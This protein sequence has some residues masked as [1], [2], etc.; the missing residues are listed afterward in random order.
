MFKNIIQGGSALLSC[1]LSIYWIPFAQVPLD[2]DAFLL[3]ILNPGDFFLGGISFLI[4]FLTHANLW[5][6][7]IVQRQQKVLL[8]YETILTWLIIF[9]PMLLM[10]FSIKIG[11]AF[12]LFSF[13]YG[14]L[15]MNV[16]TDR[17]QK[18]SHN[19]RR[20]N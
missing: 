16:R 13:V 15:S 3:T 17:Q 2:G 20:E 19:I 10:V 4:G 12:L 5:V 18:R 6:K 9:S 11:I 7:F 1:F 14:M 8:T